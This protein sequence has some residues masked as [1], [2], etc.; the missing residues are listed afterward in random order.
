M[1]GV[2]VDSDVLIE[3]LRGRNASV[4]D[5]W[6]RLAN[7][8]EAVLC[9]PVTVAEIFHGIREREQSAAEAIFSAIVCLPISPEIARKAGDYLRAFHKSHAVALGDALIAAAAQTHQLALWTNNR[10]HFPMKDVR[11]FKTG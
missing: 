7:S 8:P 11:F 5:N 6:I 10:K 4:V 3:V 1:S 9:S 2:L